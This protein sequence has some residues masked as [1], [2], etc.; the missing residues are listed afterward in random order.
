MSTVLVVDD[1]E[2]MRD[3]VGAT[4]QRAGF[5]ILAAPNGNAALDIIAKRRPDCVVT[6]LKMPG[7]TGVELLERVREFDDDLPV[8]LMTAFGDVGTAVKAMKLGAF[9]YITKP[10]EGDELLI[11]VKRGIE[12]ARLRRENAVLRLG[13]SPSAESGRVGRVD[14]GPAR[15]RSDR[16]RFARDGEAKEQIRDRVVARDGAHQ[17]RVGR[18]QGGLARAIHE[19]S[20]A[21]ASRSSR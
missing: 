9:D 11:A 4:L 12:H 3:S 10:F 17:R 8:V 1:K 13:G 21:R 6:D 15:A 18:R 7:L 5:T 2:M 16:R 20:P 14:G 19:M